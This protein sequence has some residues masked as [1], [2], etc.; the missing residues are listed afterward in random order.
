M[1]TNIKKPSLR[2]RAAIRTPYQE[3]YVNKDIRL[4]F[5]TTTDIYI[6]IVVTMKIG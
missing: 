3:V 5:E 4:K 6:Y 1:A 2:C